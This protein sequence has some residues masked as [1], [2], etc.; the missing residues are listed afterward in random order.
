MNFEEADKKANSML[1]EL[2]AGWV[3]ALQDGHGYG[4]ICRVNNGQCSVSFNENSQR[5]DAFIGSGMSFTAS[6]AFPRTALS[7]AAQKMSDN[8]AKITA[9]RNAIL[10]IVSATMAVGS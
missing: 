10:S 7:A 5:Y 3:K 9:E 6:S 8:L 1:Q 2:G 4:W